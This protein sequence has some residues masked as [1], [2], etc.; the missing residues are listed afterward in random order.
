MKIILAGCGKLGSAIIQDLVNEKHELT[1][2][3]K[4]EKAI[5]E[6]QN[7]YDV[8]TLCGN[9][10]TLDTLLTAGVAE[11]DLLIAVADKDEIN[12][13]SCVTA[14]HL[15]RKIHT[16][17][18]IRDPEY[19]EQMT[20]MQEIMGLSLIVNP[21]QS[22][23]NEIHRLL[24]FPG[25]LHRDVFANSNAEIVELLAEPKGPLDGIKLY[26]MPT[27]VHCKVLVCAM[28]R[29][30][31]G[32][33]PRG[34]DIIR[35]GDR[36]YVSAPQD[37]LDTL[38]KELKVVRKKVHSTMIL[39]GGTTSIYLANNLHR[40]GVKVKIIEEDYDVCS[41]LAN[42]LP[43]ASII[44]GSP[45]DQN[46][47]IAEGI[48]SYDSVVA[49]TSRDE[50]NSIMAFYC[51]SLNIPNVITKIDSASTIQLLNQFP[52]GSVI[53]P[54]EI[55]GAEIVRYVRAMQTESD[56]IVTMHTIADGTAEAIEFAVTEET[57]HLDTPLKK[58]RLRKNV[59]IACITK[60]SQIVIPDG[61]STY[62]AGD[63]IVIVTPQELKLAQLND[64]FE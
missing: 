21:E 23:A 36:L 6:I 14:H 50:R 62:Q 41:S 44:A 27:V 64:I 8:L 29:D 35:A 45:S 24:R 18:R 12:F 57:R 15:N 11:A 19:S 58:L 34:T 31:K 10:A 38:L 49:L 52:I 3:D 9:C 7:L 28:V 5:A 26:E 30:G 46:L 22:V 55:A 59:L 63:S 53:R 48:E 4:S 51:R 17:A 32:I 16:I 13:L 61:D 20:R 1:V 54:N 2:I 60:G 25:F 42:Q 37:S 47:L 43:F 39:G 56:S 40:S 33:I